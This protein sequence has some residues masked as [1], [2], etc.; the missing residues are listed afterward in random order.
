MQDISPREIVLL[1]PIAIAVL[2]MGIYP[3]SFLAPMRANV[4]SLVARTE[5]A[6]PV[7][8][9]KLTAGKLIEAAPHDGAHGEAH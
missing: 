3:E 1:V 2:W 6:K 5:Q 4:A 9:A 7:G 8:D